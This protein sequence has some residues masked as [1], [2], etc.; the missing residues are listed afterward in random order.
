MFWIL[1]LLSLSLAAAPAVTKPV[2]TKGKAA[3]T[4]AVNKTAAKPIAKVPAGRV[5]TKAGVPAA[6]TATPLRGA[7]ATNVRGRVQ[8]APQYSRYATNRRTATTSRSAAAARQRPVYHPA[9]MVPSSERTREI[10][11]ALA[12]KGYLKSE[13]S[14]TWDADSVDA[15]KR[16]Q[17]EQNLEADGKFSSLSLIALGLGPKRTL[18]ASSV[19]PPVTGSTPV[20][21]KP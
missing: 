2:A 9:P 1:A 8:P 10:Q 18:T 7:P 6:R 15:M 16:F 21:A 14:G 17:K 5:P 19:N 20:P 4:K 13:P 12:Q 3:P 11:S